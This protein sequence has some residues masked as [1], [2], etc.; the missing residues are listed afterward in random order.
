[1]SEIAMPTPPEGMYWTVGTS[2]GMYGEERWWINVRLWR[3]RRRWLPLPQWMFDKLVDTELEEAT[4]DPEVNAAR[5]VN[6]AKKVLD[7]FKF[8]N[9]NG[10]TG[11]RRM[12]G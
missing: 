10:L 9:Y 1:M 7:N 6:L 4:T 12:P 2:S 8:Y 5:A 11:Y 3:S